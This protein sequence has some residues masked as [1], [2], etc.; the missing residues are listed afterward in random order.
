MTGT[1]SGT[2]GLIGGGEGGAGIGGIG[3]PGF[4]GTGAGDGSGNGI[5]ACSSRAARPEDFVNDVVMASAY[6]ALG[7]SNVVLR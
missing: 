6:P 4:G 2:S 1:S 7:S 5:D 3:S